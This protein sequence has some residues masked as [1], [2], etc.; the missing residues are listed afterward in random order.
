VLD[1]ILLPYL[2]HGTVSI[3][4]HYL[5]IFYTEFHSDRSRNAE[6]NYAGQ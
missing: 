1:Y 2:M 4:Q 5:V 6:V 3:H